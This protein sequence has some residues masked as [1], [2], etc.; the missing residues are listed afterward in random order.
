V[1]YHAKLI[2]GG[3]MVIPAALRRELGFREGD[4]LVIEREGDGLVVRSLAQVVRD[5][6]CKVKDLVKSPFTLDDYLAEKHAEAE[7]ENRQ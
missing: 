4:C 5:V 7:L 1:T 6:Q 2:K 3:K